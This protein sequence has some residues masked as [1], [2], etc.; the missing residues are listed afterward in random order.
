[1]LKKA[2]FAWS[3]VAFFCSIKKKEKVVFQGAKHRYATINCEMCTKN[4]CKIW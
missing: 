2:T 4:G 1:M 3:N